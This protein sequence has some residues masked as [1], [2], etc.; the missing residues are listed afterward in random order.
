VE[1]L[2]ATT[3][4]VPSLPKTKPFEDRLLTYVKLLHEDV[5][6]EPNMKTQQ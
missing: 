6:F 5:I 1:A 3:F 4:A 2:P